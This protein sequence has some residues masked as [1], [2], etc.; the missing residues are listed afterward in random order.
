M[1]KLFKKIIRVPKEGSSF[2]YFLLEA[3]EGLC[4]YS[5]ID[6]GKGLP[7]RDLELVGPLEFKEATEH[8]LERFKGQH[9]YEYLSDEVLEDAKNITSLLVT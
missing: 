7:F 1:F 5:T 3:H 4:F 9:S 6:P 2:L 8:L